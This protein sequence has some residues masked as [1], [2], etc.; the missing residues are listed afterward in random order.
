[1]AFD[2]FKMVEEDTS[3]LTNIEK[4]L[5]LVEI[6]SNAQGH[7]RRA[8]KQDHLKCS[9]MERKDLLEVFRHK[10]KWYFRN[11]YEMYSGVKKKN[12]ED[13]MDMSSTYSS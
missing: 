12:F 11:K 5:Q 4:M 10:Y 3:E 7:Q 2:E 13:I 6:M 1:M 9:L 8:M